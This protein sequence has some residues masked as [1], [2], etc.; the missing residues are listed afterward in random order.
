MTATTR[1]AVIYSAAGPAT[2]AAVWLVIEGV[3]L[4]IG[5]N[6]VLTALE[7]W[8]KWPAWQARIGIGGKVVV[9]PEKR[10]A[11]AARDAV[12]VALGLGSVQ[13]IEWDDLQAAER[14]ISTMV[15]GAVYAA[16]SRAARAEGVSLREFV[17]QA[18]SD[19]LEARERAS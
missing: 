11:G 7:D 15:E 4:T 3:P 18:L 5:R 8:Q 17:R 10:W 19:A 13:R 9:L 6:A 16:V 2:P 14:S 1:W 12:S